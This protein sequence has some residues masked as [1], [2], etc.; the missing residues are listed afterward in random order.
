MRNGFA[1]KRKRNIGVGR[2]PLHLR[3]V[4]ELRVDGANHLQQSRVRRKF[5][6]RAIADLNNLAL[7]GLSAS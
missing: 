7:H 4:A 5:A 1:A 3:R 2:G 6:R